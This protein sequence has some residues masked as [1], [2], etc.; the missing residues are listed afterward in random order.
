MS[1]LRKELNKTLPK[2]HIKIHHS[3]FMQ[4]RMEISNFIPETR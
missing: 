1:E 4:S 2:Y 3:P